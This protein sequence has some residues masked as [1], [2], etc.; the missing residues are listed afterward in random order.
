MLRPLPLLW[1]SNW[2]ERTKSSLMTHRWRYWPWE[3]RVQTK[4]EEIVVDRNGGHDLATVVWLEISVHFANWLDIER[5]IVW[6]SRRRTSWRRNQWNHHR[7]MSP[8][9][10]EIILIIL[11]SRFLLHRLYATHWLLDTGDTYHICSRN[12]WFSSLEKLDSGVVIM[13][14]DDA[15]QIVMIGTVRINMFD[16][17]VRDLT[18]IR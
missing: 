15:C 13:R 16:V 10:M 11:L 8:S 17:V 2:D 18:D 7:W 1:I 12:E 4:K 3:E 9:P 14:N 6:S 5:K